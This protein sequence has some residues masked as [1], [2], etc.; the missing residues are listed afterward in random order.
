MVHFYDKW[1]KNFAR[2]S[3]ETRQIFWKNGIFQNIFFLPNVYPYNKNSSCKI[4]GYL[5][6][7]KINNS[8]IKVEF[9][10]FWPNFDIELWPKMQKYAM[11]YWLASIPLPL[12]VPERET[13]ALRSAEK[14][15]QVNICKASFFHKKSNPTKQIRSS[16]LI[17]NVDQMSPNL[18]QR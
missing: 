11:N 6:I 3:P 2:F 16:L 14:K 18:V 13:S 1:D 7:Q 9:H 4:W 8:N 10:V 5:I 15:V 12:G 17:M